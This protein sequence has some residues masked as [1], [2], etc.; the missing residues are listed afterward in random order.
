MTAPD[1]GKLTAQLQQ[2][3]LPPVESWQPPLSGEMDMRIARDGVWWH[4]GKPIR[5]ES[6]VRLFSTILRREDDDC[7]YLLTPVEKWRIRVDDAPFVAVVLEVLDVGETRTLVFHTN[8]GDKIAAGPEHPLRV[9]YDTAGEPSPY[10]HVRA[11]LWALISRSVFLELAELAQIQ[12]GND[13][14]VYTVHSQGSCFVLGP[15]D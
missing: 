9:E 5:R 1:P 12:Q 11:A 2:R 15:A 14:Q 10:I 8:V 4:E 7:Y 13:G 3:S 6:L